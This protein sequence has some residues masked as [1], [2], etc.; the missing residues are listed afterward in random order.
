MNNTEIIVIVVILSLIF[1]ISINSCSHINN[2]LL[3]INNNIVR[4]IMILF[5]ITVGKYNVNI[6]GLVGLLFLIMINKANHIEGLENNDNS[7][8]TNLNLWLGIMLINP[9]KYIF[10][11]EKYNIKQ[12][13]EDIKL[14]DECKQFSEK[15]LEIMDNDTVHSIAIL[16]LAT[17]SNNIED[18]SSV[19]KTLKYEDMII[20]LESLLKDDQLIEKQMKENLSIENV[21]KQKNGKL[22]KNK[23]L[24]K[25]LPF[26]NNNKECAM[27]LFNKVVNEKLTKEQ[28]EKII[29][30]IDY[31]QV[32]KTEESEQS[33]KPTTIEQKK[34]PITKEQLIKKSNED[35]SVLKCDD[36]LN[37]E[38]DC[39][40]GSVCS[41]GFYCKIKEKGTG[42]K[43]LCSPF[44]NPVIC[45]DGRFTC[46][47]DSKCVIRQKCKDFDGNL[48]DQVMSSDGYTKNNE[49]SQKTASTKPRVSSQSISSKP[50][51]SSESTSQQELRRPSVSS[52]PAS[53]PASRKPSV[54]SQPASQPASRKPSVSSQPASQQSSRKP[55]VS[56]QSNKMN[57]NASK[58][59]IH[60][61]QLNYEETD[62]MDSLDYTIPI[63]KYFP[64]LNNT[65][66]RKN[67]HNPSYTVPI[68]N[69]GI[70]KHDFNRN[71]HLC[72]DCK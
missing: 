1:L 62:V 26:L 27:K 72:P 13:I 20:D 28:I 30:N 9:I 51:V 38:D 35:D 70:N 58:D 22:D 47:S 71:R 15:Y 65:F 69:C 41:K 57:K 64:K 66:D 3:Y 32:K 2:I 48:T 11:N 37:E 29:N 7:K 42:S 19:F 6:G 40:N 53:Q 55:S 12:E 31:E 68:V 50:S 46:P 5:I 44:M 59:I 49:E 17:Q 33:T 14:M 56:S 61:N 16:L 43:H 10:I 8:Y 63:A 45:N 36:E 23:I 21:I 52:Q 39:N 18:I 25:L 24:T 60:S 34:K 67:S 4:F 54:S